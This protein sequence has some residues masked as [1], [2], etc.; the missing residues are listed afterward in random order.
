MSWAD[1]QREFASRYVDGV[2]SFPKAS[3]RYEWW[4]VRRAPGGGGLGSLLWLLW[5]VYR[6]IR[7]I[8]EG[9]FVRIMDDTER[10]TLGVEFA[11]KDSSFDEP[12]G[13]GAGIIWGDIKPGGAL[14]LETESGPVFPTHPPKMS[15]SAA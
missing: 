14:V 15:R 8:D 2:T 13:S 9:T 3:T 5:T 11:V 7:G 1:A 6:F 12:K 10:Q 4:T